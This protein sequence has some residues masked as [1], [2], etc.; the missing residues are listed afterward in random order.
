M[1][2]LYLFLPISG[3][4]LNPNFLIKPNHLQTPIAIH[5]FNLL[6]AAGD[7]KLVQ[8]PRLNA[9]H[10]LEDIGFHPAEP[11]AIVIDLAL[12]VRVVEI[13]APAVDADHAQ[14]LL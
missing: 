9:V 14:V 2:R 10:F 5:P 6:T 8:L 11:G 1:E 12:T 4:S 7:R 13:D 3:H